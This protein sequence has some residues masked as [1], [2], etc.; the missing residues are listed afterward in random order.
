[1]RLNLNIKRIGGYGTKIKL[2]K[3]KTQHIKKLKIETFEI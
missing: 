3:C 2:R 1:M